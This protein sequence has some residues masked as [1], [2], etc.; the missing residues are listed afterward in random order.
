MQFSS[1]FERKTFSNFAFWN[2]YCL[3]PR[4]FGV[5]TRFC[6]LLLVCVLVCSAEDGEEALD[7]QLRDLVDGIARHDRRKA[8]GYVNWLPIIHHVTQQD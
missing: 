2:I 3:F 1:F 4:F 8:T 7:S 6:V 5:L